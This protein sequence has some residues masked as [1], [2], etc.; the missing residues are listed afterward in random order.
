MFYL[1]AM[2]TPTLAERCA[3]HFTVTKCT[4]SGSSR[5]IYHVVDRSVEQRRAW[6]FD[7][8]I[9]TWE[10]R[11][12]DGSKYQVA[13]RERSTGCYWSLYLYLRSDAI[14]E[15]CKWINSLR[16]DPAF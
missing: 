2:K 4:Q 13:I 10:H 16:A 7:I 11:A 9:L 8:D 12:E 3:L 6:R 1:I 15:I 14:N 5:R